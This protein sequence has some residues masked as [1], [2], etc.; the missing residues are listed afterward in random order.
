MICRNEHDKDEIAKLVFRK[1]KLKGEL[2][3]TLININ[4]DSK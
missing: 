4:T 3:L 1:S 2:N